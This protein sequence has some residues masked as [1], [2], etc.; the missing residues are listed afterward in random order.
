MADLECAAHAED[1]V[2]SLLG[3]KALKGEK[4][5]IGLFGDQVVGSVAGERVSML[6]DVSRTKDQ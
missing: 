6:F 1:T 2:V 4:D 3:R 5:N